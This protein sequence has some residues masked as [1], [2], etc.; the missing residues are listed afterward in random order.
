MKK[1]LTKSE[2]KIVKYYRYINYSVVLLF[3]I[4][5]FLTKREN[6]DIIYI[7][8]AVF[9]LPLLI[10]KLNNDIKI[11]RNSKTKTLKKMLLSMVIVLI[12][13]VIFYYT[14]VT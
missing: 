6:R 13:L 1:F 9:M 2:N 5:I 10:I 8:F 14:K 4:T 12:V 11:D 3:I 7:I